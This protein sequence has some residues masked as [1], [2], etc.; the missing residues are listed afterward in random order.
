MRLTQPQSQYLLTIGAIAVACFLSAR[1]AA[2]LLN[3]GIEASPV[4]APAGIALAMLL[5]HGRQVW[6]GIALGTLLFAL[7]LR[8]PWIVAGVAALGSTLEAIAAQWFMQRFKVYASLRNLRDVLGFIALA[9]ILAPA[10]NATIS[11]LNGCLAGINAWN[12][13]SAHWWMIWLGDGIGILI[14]TPLLLIWLSQPLPKM[15]SWRSLLPLW[16]QNSIL[17]QR[18]LEFLVWAILLVTVSWTV[19][20]STPKTAIAQYP[21]EYLPFP[22]IA[23]AALRLGQRGTILGSLLVSGI[24]IWGAVRQAGPFLAKSGGNVIQAVF[25]LQA[26]VG[27]MTVTALV[28]AAVVAERQQVEDRL[29]RSETS[30]L[31]AQRI[32]RLGNWDLT[33]PP[34]CRCTPDVVL[35]TTYLRWSDELYR[36]VGLPP[37]SIQPSLE[38]FWTIV[39]P[40]DRDRHQQAVQRAIYDRIPYSLDYRLQLP[41]GSERL[42]SEQVEICSAGITGTVQDITAW[43]HVEVALRER[44]EQFRSMFEGAA[45]GIG[46]NNLQGQIMASNPVLQA[47]LGYSHDELSHMTF[48]EFT[49]PDDLAADIE[50]FE[51]MIAGRRDSYQLEKRHIRKDGRV[52]WVRLT[53]SL[54]RDGA[55][56]PKF[57][58]AMVEDITE[59]KQAEQRIRL[60]ADIVKNMQLGLLVWQL[61][62]PNNLTSFRL[63][64]CNPA[65]RQILG[66]TINQADLIG[67]CMTELFPSLLE[68]AFPGIYA[69]VI[70]TGTVRDLGEVCY[71][72]PAVSTGIYATKA[73]PLPN[74]C[75]GLV[76]EDISDRKQ[77]E[78]ALQQS[79]A[80]FRVVAETATC[81]IMVYQD[82]YL[83]YVN[84]ATE[85]IS[86]YSRHE[87]LSMRFW[88]LAHPEFRDLVQQRG[89]ARQRGE[90]VPG[91]YEL[92]ILTK[93]GKV[94]WLDFTAGVIDYGGRP[95]GLATAYDITDR[96][97]AEDR[98]R[99][100]AERERLLAELASRIRRDLNLDEVLNTT[101]KEVRQFLNADR[102][103]IA[104]LDQTG[105]CHTVAESVDPQWPSVMRW[106]IDKDS[107]QEIYSLFDR[108]R[109]RVVND[110]DRVDKTPF[111]RDYYR[112]GQIRA[113]IAVLLVV[114]ERMFGVLIV[115]QCSAPRQWQAFEIELLQQLATQVEIAVQQ[116]QLY[117]QLQTLAVNLESQVE[118]RTAQLHQQMQELQH[119]NQVKDILLHA[120]SHDLK[121]PIQGM[122]MLLNHLRSRGDDTVSV[123]N[124]ILDRMIQCSDH[125]LNL[126]NS[127]LEH[128]TDVEPKIALNCEP[129][130][131][132]NIVDSV[133]NH[134]RLL[135]DSNRITLVDQR[136]VDLPAVKADR[137]QLQR[138]LEHLVANAVKHNPPGI[139]ITMRA[140]LLQQEE[141]RVLHSEFTSQLPQMVYCTVEDSGVGMSQEQC[142]RLFQLYVRGLDNAHLTGIGLG[143][144]C[145]HQI[146]RAHSGQIGV[147][148][149]LGKGSK[150]WFTLPLYPTSQPL[151]QTIT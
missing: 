151:A 80:R 126:L 127:L 95:A 130:H 142:D 62:E 110:T 97:Q 60:Y 84:P 67:K 41:D 63:I 125:Q 10:I 58:I 122:L 105:G 51:A 1:L 9:V 45:I 4:W 12:Q 107:V 90:V 65:A 139:T 76:F 93:S 102:V 106:I 25:L 61:Q 34:D 28:L 118:E 91:R 66:I 14:G 136:S 96:K 20:Q 115:N 92:K 101:V 75:V 98:L 119:L 109:I 112:R 89:L 24:A 26:F 71:G 73:F 79:E 17:H 123:P 138:L 13:F 78:A 148:S 38:T 108:D 137:I 56:H 88:D 135:L 32:A 103:F 37:G 131:L 35:S 134:L 36:I 53:N 140:I 133:T 30:L 57:T 8:V 121:T 111:L 94:R 147:T 85:S 74:S 31:N 100:A 18:A 114:D 86:E 70:Q 144:H 49:H 149:T 99:T 81:A 44:E 15:R 146:I 22:F 33:F 87:L 21:L 16:Q 50:Q 52:V 43:K 59:L 83:C 23:W 46:L 69:T 150:F 5:L 48:A 132:A 64:E 40:D 113:G 55:G 42:I 143:L 104:H 29:R 72:D 120:V 11:S 116:G 39:H 7:S 19:F 117:R 6:V 54:V 2:L 68:T 141:F 145:C 129:I 47:T 128:H 27:V 82:D 3:L 77:A 124:S